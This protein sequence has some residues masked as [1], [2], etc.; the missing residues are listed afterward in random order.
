[1]AIVVLDASVVIAFLD[2]SDTHH[3]AAVAA[4]TS[5]GSEELVLPASAYSE[6]L[7]GPA[8]RGR[9]VLAVVRE[10]VTDLAL[11]V[12]PL[13]SAIAERAAALRAAHRSLR[14]PDALVLATADTSNAAS[15]LTA[16][17]SWAKISERVRAI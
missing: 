5:V 7:V 6:V 17:R 12:A 2:A 9:D 11:R 15:V 8:R 1:V 16:D 10:F 3:Q 14:L 4:L 13:D